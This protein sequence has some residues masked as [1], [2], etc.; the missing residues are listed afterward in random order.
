MWV[1]ASVL[2]VRVLAV[3]RGAGGARRLRRERRGQRQEGDHR[4]VGSRRPQPHQR[5]AADPPREHP[6]T[7]QRS[8]HPPREHP[9]AVQWSVHPP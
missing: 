9:F 1:L 4:P 6:L 3:P 5:E 8:V 2:A 7:V